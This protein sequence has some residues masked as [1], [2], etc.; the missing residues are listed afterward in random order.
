[1]TALQPYETPPDRLTNYY[2]HTM[3]LA[4]RGLL[5]YNHGAYP[6]HGVSNNAMTCYWQGLLADGDGG[7]VLT[8]LG[9]RL[10]A[11]WWASPE[12]QWYVAANMD[13]DPW[14]AAHALPGTVPAP[15]PFSD[16]PPRLHA[17]EEET[18]T[19]AAEQD[20]LFEV[21]A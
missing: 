7:M 18:P 1:M 14:I 8:D 17:I 3:Q 10:L 5:R 2:V 13:R 19:A 21:P 4:E 15:E 6:I 12:G 20:A 9:R 16:C 11:E